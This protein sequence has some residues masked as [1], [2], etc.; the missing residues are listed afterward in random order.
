MKIAIVER[1]FGFVFFVVVLGI[2]AT[3]ARC[4]RSIRMFFIDCARVVGFG[5]HRASGR[6]NEPASRRVASRRVAGPQPS[7]KPKRSH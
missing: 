2:V 3:G 7:S 5:P 1:V 4:E 6:M